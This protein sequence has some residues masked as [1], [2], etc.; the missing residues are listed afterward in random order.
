VSDL[1]SAI[2]TGHYAQKQLFSRDRLVAWSHTRRFDTGIALAREFRGKRVLDFGSGD[3][4]FL[5]LTMMS[6]DAPA[7][8]AGAEI[9][10]EVVDDCRRRYRTEPRLQFLQ[11]NELDEPGSAGAYDAVFCMEVLE[12]VVDWEP[13][14]TRMSRL[15]APGGKLIVSVPVE[16][17]LP[18]LVKQT[19]R[20]IAGWRKI[21]HYPGTS[22][23]SWRELVSAVV[24]GNRPHLARP[25]FDTGSGPSHDHKGFNWMVLRDR[26]SRQF[27]VER[28]LASPFPWLGPRLATQV[29]FVCRLNRL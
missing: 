26:L 17:G 4:T 10:R 25:V 24:A 8:A 12:H 5:A 29:W 11:V 7:M 22:S 6:D 9:T 20:R 21:G 28:V 2:T 16:T 3:G 1:R 18:V 14:L 27:T 23:Y 13:E 15:L 19:V